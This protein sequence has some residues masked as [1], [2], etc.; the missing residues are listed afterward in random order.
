M[1]RVGSDT[2]FKD[3]LDMASKIELVN[4]IPTSA[5]EQDSYSTTTYLTRLQ[6]AGLQLLSSRCGIPI[7][8][9][10]REAIDL[11]LLVSV[12]QGR[13]NRPPRLSDLADA[14]LGSE[15]G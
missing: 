4:L 15:K 5:G 10:I 7:A 9:L 13:F 11:Q 14:A 6:H 12:R 2:Q 3:E 8:D 1:S